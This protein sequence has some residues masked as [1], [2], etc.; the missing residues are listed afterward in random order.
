[1]QGICES[2]RELYGHALLQDHQFPEA[3]F[4]AEEI[5][6]R[7]QALAATLKGEADG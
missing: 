6:L 5:A 1:M 2:L 3:D 4:T 7:L